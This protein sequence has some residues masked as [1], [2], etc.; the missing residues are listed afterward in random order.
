MAHRSNSGSGKL[1]N[2]LKVGKRRSYAR[3]RTQHGDC[4]S[5]IFFLFSSF[6]KKEKQAKNTLYFGLPP[7][8]HLAAIC[9]TYDRERKAKSLWRD[10][11]WTGRRP[12]AMRQ[13]A[14]LTVRVFQGSLAESH[15]GQQ[16]ARYDCAKI[17][18][19]A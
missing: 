5:S 10:C 12:K 15:G 9:L 3:I 14:S 17:S 6:R 4:I 16:Q 18:Y 7:F 1:V 13:E 19:P 8:L 11:I 2:R